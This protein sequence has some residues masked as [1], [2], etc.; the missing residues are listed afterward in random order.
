VLAYVFSHR[1]AEG[2]DVA[3]YEAGLKRFHFALAAHPPA[4]FNSSGSYRVDGGYAD[5]YLV[6]NSAALDALNDA[7]VTGARARPHDEVAL[8][9]AAGS[10]KLMSLVSGALDPLA[11]FEIGF[12]K[13][14]GMSYADLVSALL[15]WTGRA[16]VSLW[17]RMMVLGPPPEFCLLARSELDLPAVIQPETRS[18]QP[19]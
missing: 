18:R 2:A 8:A 14:A 3:R 5:W 9:A 16:G 1:P 4:G 11:G 6:E 13:P 19:I 17:K 10:G 7:A 12:S 15:P